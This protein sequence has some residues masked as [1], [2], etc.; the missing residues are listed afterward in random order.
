V[1]TTELVFEIMAKFAVLT[2]DP[3]ASAGGGDVSGLAGASS[4]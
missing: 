4:S 1:N 3:A 2:A